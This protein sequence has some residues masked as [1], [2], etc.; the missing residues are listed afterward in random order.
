M[1]PM[2]QDTALLTVILPTKVTEP[3]VL[4]NVK[5]ST[6]KQ[7]QPKI[8]AGIKPEGWKR[9]KTLLISIHFFPHYFS[10]KTEG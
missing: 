1:F 7:Q 6:K 10:L 4:E 9:M 8:K 5:W 2:L 3:V